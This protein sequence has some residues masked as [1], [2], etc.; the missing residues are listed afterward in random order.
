MSLD[1]QF[2]VS[3][4]RH[5]YIH[6]ARQPFGIHFGFAQSTGDTHAT[7]VIDIV[8]HLGI[9]RTDIGHAGTI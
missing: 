6:A 3:L 1:F 4:W 9:V 7:Y 5:K 8:H 2:F